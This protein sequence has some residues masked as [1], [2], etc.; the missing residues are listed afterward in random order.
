MVKLC[1]SLFH[2]DVVFFLF[3]Q[4]A[5]VSQLA[6]KYF[7]VFRHFVFFSE[8]KSNLWLKSSK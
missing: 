1:P 2:L 8:D 5:A 6:F 7:I 3:A 4:C